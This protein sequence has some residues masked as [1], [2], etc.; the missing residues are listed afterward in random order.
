M[1][2]CM[3]IYLFICLCIHL[4]VIC[5][6][7]FFYLFIIIIIFFC[8]NIASIIS[9]QSTCCYPCET[10]VKKDYQPSCTGP[11]DTF[12]FFNQVLVGGP[13]TNGDDDDDDKVSFESVKAS[14]KGD[15]SFITQRY[16]DDNCQNLISTSEGD[17]DLC[18][19]GTVYR[20]NGAGNGPDSSSSSKVSTAVI[21][22]SAAGGVVLIAV[23]VIAVCLI[24]KR[25]AGYS[26]LSG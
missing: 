19:Y 10:C 15:G 3:S 20:C 6:I 13:S 23:V 24:K 21:A 8:F 12:E 14:C 17:L 4:F 18:R 5:F 16:S 25:R 11:L 22:G 9:P 26:H 2:I 7:A 1:K